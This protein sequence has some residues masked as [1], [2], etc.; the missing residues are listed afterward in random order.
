MTLQLVNKEAPLRVVVIKILQ[1]MAE[2][3]LHFQRTESIDFIVAMLYQGR[4][5]VQQISTT[6]QFLVRSQIKT[7]NRTGLFRLQNTG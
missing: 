6:S 5:H 2:G 7:T 1:R 3:G 4:L